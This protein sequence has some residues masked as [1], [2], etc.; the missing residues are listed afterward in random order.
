MESKQTVVRGGTSF[1]SVALV[2]TLVFF[3][4]KV[5]NVL[6]WS[7]VWVLSPLWIWAALLIGTLFL[8]LFILLVCTIISDAVK[9]RRRSRRY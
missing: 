7:W 4:L 5:T 8:F 6:T 9:S 2:I 1:F 3:I